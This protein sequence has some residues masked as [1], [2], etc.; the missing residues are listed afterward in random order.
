[1]DELSSLSGDSEGQLIPE[2]KDEETSK[3]TIKSGTTNKTQR[4]FLRTKLSLL[5]YSLEEQRNTSSYLREERDEAVNLSRTLQRELQE[6]RRE[7]HTGKRLLPAES[8]EYK[9][10]GSWK[11]GP[12]KEEQNVVGYMIAVPRKCVRGLVNRAALFVW[13]TGVWMNEGLGM[14]RIQNKWVELQRINCELQQENAKLAQETYDLQR[15]LAEKEFEILGEIERN[16]ELTKR[17]NKQCG[18]S[19]H[20]GSK[21]HPLEKM[22]KHV[23]AIADFSECL[24]EEIEKI[25]GKMD[26]RFAKFERVY[27]DI[28]RL[29]EGQRLLEMAE[30]DLQKRV[31]TLGASN[32][33]GCCQSSCESSQDQETEKSV[34]PS[35]TIQAVYE[36]KATC[37]RGRDKSRSK[38]FRRMLW[39]SCGLISSG[40]RAVFIF[41]LLFLTLGFLFHFLLLSSSLRLPSSFADDYYGVDLFALWCYFVN[42]VF[43]L[44]VNE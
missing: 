40:C 32:A 39:R 22:A 12:L 36:S 35:K 38:M 21:G 29:T 16:K 6:L 44:L 19:P 30:R 1:M 3:D 23:H 37:S 31:K 24:S 7:I 25:K 15:L 26:R 4:D 42:W 34:P 11:T 5:Q 20:S 27:H 10:S 13:W 8:S 17:L 18:A 41:L 9:Q 14:L 2:K 33:H 28:G 43:H